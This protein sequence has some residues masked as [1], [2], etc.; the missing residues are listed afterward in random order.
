MGAGLAALDGFSAISIPSS[1]AFSFTALATAS[2]VALVALASTT[3][4]WASTAILAPVVATFDAA[5]TGSTFP[6]AASFAVLVIDVAPLAKSPAVDAIAPT[7]AAATPAS[8]D[9][10][11]IAFAALAATS[12]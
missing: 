4:G 6:V 7:G 8:A 3:S 9:A 12:A 10:G 2:V 5:V 1:P 11:F